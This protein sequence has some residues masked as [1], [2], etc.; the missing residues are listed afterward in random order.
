[1][2][3]D[4]AESMLDLNSSASI[5]PGSLQAPTFP[6]SCSA[7]STAPELI[8]VCGILV[9]RES[10]FFSKDCTSL[11]HKGS[12]IL[13][14]VRMV[15]D[16]LWDSVSS[17]VH[18]KWMPRKKER[19]AHINFKWQLSHLHLCLALCFPGL[20]YAIS[21]LS[22][23]LISFRFQTQ[24]SVAGSQLPWILG[25]SIS[26]RLAAGHQNGPV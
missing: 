6:P 9:L 12:H 2:S 11:N 20:S 19:K 3:P 4:L 23:Y 14:Q 16:L 24:H 18:L 5:K 17:A 8:N 7:V 21:S 26:G 25:C 1:M 22:V 15:R 10:G 13:Y